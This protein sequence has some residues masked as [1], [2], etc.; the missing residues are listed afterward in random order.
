MGQFSA[1]FF[2]LPDWDSSFGDLECLYNIV[3]ILAW[4]KV[5]DQQT[6]TAIQK[7]NG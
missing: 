5:L 1:M 4:T 6:G 7:M 3:D 2:G